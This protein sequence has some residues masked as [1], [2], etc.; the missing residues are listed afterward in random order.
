MF[1]QMSNQGGS[2]SLSSLQASRSGET[3]TSSFEGVCYSS[4][5]LR[6]TLNLLSDPENLEFPWSHNKLTWSFRWTLFL[7]R[8]A[9]LSVL[10]CYP[11]ISVEFFWLPF[12]HIIQ[13]YATY[14]LLIKLSWKPFPLRECLITCASL[15]NKKNDTHRH[16]KDKD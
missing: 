8:A 7:K 12:S 4:N 1:K 15:D 9:G 11:Y 6:V 5:W 10:G 3:W 13:K 2:S 16:R 14:S